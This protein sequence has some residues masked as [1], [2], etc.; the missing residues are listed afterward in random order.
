MGENRG[1]GWLQTVG[2]VAFTGLLAAALTRGF[3]E[4]GGRVAAPQS[5]HAPA[6][7]RMITFLAV[8]DINLGRWVGQQILKGDTLYPFMHV[9]DTLS[10]YD[11]VF[12][13]LESNISDQKGKTQYPGNNIIFTAPPAAAYS[14][15]R[16]GI[17]VVATAN[18]HAL[19]FGVSALNQTAVYLDS[20][21]ISHAGTGGELYAPALLTVKGIRL[22]IFAVTDIMNMTD[23]RWKRYVAEADTAALLPAL[24]RIRDSVDIVIVSCHGGDEYADRPTERTRSFARDVLAGGADIFLGH[25]PHV[26]Y[27]IDFSGRG[28]AV[29]SLGNFVFKQPDRY[30]T[31]HSY[32]LAARIVQDSSGTRVEGLRA[33]PLKADFQPEFLSGGEDADRIFRRIRTLSSHDAWERTTW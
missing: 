4:N 14:L 25:H 32:A 9:R 2:L 3:D 24:R 22:A 7:V 16:G 26:P 11:V 19:D 18:N 13:N 15:K 30:W 28:F 31:T 10:A 33:L 23:G 8:G 12:A 20:A 29:H 5:G 6:R 21:G 17:T 1:G 27:G